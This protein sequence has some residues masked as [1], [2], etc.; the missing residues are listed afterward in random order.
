MIKPRL[1]I[2]LMFVAIILVMNGFTS[3]PR[4]ATAQPLE[5][6]PVEALQRLLEGNS[7]YVSGH[8]EHPNYRPSTAPQR[9]IAVILSCSDSRVPLEIIFDQGIGD[10]FVVRVAGNTY[11]QLLLETIEFGVE[12]LGARLILVMG[13]DQCGAVTAAVKEYPDP[14]VGEMIKNIYPAI[15]DAKDAKGDLV[16][17]AISINAVLVAA[18]LAAE[19]QLSHLVAQG[20]L[21][22]LPA[23]YEM[24]TGRVKIL[25]GE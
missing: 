8:P 25:G 24:A 7:R 1:V 6:A 20:K 18:R 4:A 21:K 17:A 15:K 14:H 9:P 22:I 3:A 10:V 5:I 16:S 11:D 23:R 13:H 2:G 12:N 19:P